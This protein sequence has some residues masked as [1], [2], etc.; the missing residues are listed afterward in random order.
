MLQ[1]IRKSA[2]WLCLALLGNIALADQSHRLNVSAIVPPQPCQYPEICEP[3][4]ANVAT[5]VTI[6]DGEVHYVGSPPEVTQ[7]DDLMTILF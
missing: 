3:V 5:K 4:Q 7:S 1:R 6:E 2:W